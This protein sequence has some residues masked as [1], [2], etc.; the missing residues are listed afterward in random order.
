MSGGGKA[1]LL[2]D[3]DLNSS[4][5]AAPASVDEVELGLAGGGETGGA[6]KN[7]LPLDFVL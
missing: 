5:A 4:S 6:V 7:M 2:Q 1:S 3:V